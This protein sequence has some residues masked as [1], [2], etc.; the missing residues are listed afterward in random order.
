MTES[1]RKKLLRSYCESTANRMQKICS[2][3]PDCTVFRRVKDC[4]LYINQ[5]RCAYGNLLAYNE[6]VRQESDK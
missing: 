3:H 4:P 2:L 1:K 5:R 6:R